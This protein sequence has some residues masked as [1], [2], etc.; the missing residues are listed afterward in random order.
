MKSI[1]F[2]I[3]P[4]S[5]LCQFD[6]RYCFYK[7]V[8]S[9]REL[10]SMGIMT[11]ETAHKLILEAVNMLGEDGTL[12]FG[13]QGG[14]PTLAGLEYFRDFVEYVNKVKKNQKVDYSFQTNGYLIDTEW[15]EFFKENN[16]LIGIS[17]DGYKEVNDFMR[18]INNQGSFDSI[19]NA[20]KLL[21]KYEIEYNILT[22]LTK[23]LAK[24]P[25]K[26]YQFYKNN[27]FE[28]IQ[29]IPCLSKLDSTEKDLNSLTPQLF[30]E[31][32][33]I[34]FKLWF[35]D[36]IMKESM[37]IT[38]FDDTFDLL[39]HRIPITCG[40]N[41]ICRPQYIIEGNGNVYFCDFYVL[42]EYCLGNINDVSLMTINKNMN[43]KFSSFKKR[44]NS[45][46]CFKCQ[47]Y[48]LCHGS[49]KRLNSSFLEESYCGYEKFIIFMIDYLK[50]QECIK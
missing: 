30:Y 48:G 43:L 6:C 32:Y 9:R 40:A 7:D 20:I 17:I 3:K 10:E 27:N 41:G 34:F 44:K 5:S 33:K 15:C 28:Y 42:D 38:L 36:N 39:N 45:E 23:Q 25:S 19:L 22:V 26:L 29:L 21:K 49:C 4:A 1:S 47:F 31:F 12:H 24:H 50:E 8:S 18:R 46:Y 16:F 35:K 13:F 14:E 11:K 37:H 2:L